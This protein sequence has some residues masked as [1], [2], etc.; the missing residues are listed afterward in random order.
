[1]VTT[2]INKAETSQ[3][4]QENKSDI[5]LN[6]P[7]SEIAKRIDREKVEGFLSHEEGELL[8]YLA[9]S[10]PN[11]GTIVEIGSWKGRSTAWMGRG[12]KG[13]SNNA[14]I[15]AIDPHTG[16]PEHQLN[17]VEVYTFTE[18]KNN[19]RNMGV[20]DVITPIVAFSDEAAKDFVL[21]VDLLFIDGAHEY[22]AVKLDFDTWFPKLKIG[23][24][25][26]FHD[27][28]GEG[29]PGV[30]QLVREEVYTSDRFENVRFI[31]S[32]TY[33]TKVKEKEGGENYSNK[34]IFGLKCIHD[35]RKK[36]P[37]PFRNL[38]R[39]IVTKCFQKSWM[40]TERRKSLK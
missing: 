5:P 30:Q 20:E 31:G 27:S 4:S 32:I 21:P 38:E 23:A 15:Y 36:I 19:V 40:K 25:I 39:L 14:H 37:Q 8:H 22:E 28:V 3:Q 35:A 24:T 17:S 26:A 18:F 16:S 33:A 7:V 34:A 29:W 12:V 2:E 9:R 11:N 10:C 6:E 1:M 13:A